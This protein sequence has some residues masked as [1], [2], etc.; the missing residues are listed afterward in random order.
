MPPVYISGHRNPDTDSIGAA[1]GYAELKSHLDPN[2][3]Y[4]PVRLGELNPQT[5]WVLEQAGLPAPEYLS[6]VHLR[7][8]DLMQTEFPTMNAN[9]SIREAGLALDHTDYDLVPVI[10]DEGIL[11][12][13]ITTRSLARRYVRE[14]RESSVLREATS[15]RA[16]VDV[17]DG[18]LLNGEDRTLSGRIWVHA[19]APEA[20]TGIQHS[21]I[22]V[23]GDRNA[24]QRRIIEKGVALLALSRGT[25]P[26]P[27]VLAFAKEKGVAMI[28]SPLDTYVTARMI[29]LAGPCREL[30]ENDQIIATPDELIAE[31]SE[32]IKDSHHGAAIIV[33]ERQRPIGL[34]TRSDLVSPLRRRVILVDH[35]EQ[36]QSVPGIEQA[37]IVEILD[38][39]H[40]GS[41]ETK[42]P[43]TAT[44]DPV[45]STATLVIERF[46]RSGVEPSRPT[47]MLLLAAVLADTVI[48]N[49]PTTTERDAAVVEYLERVLE[50]DAQRFG[51]RMFAETSD[52]SDVSAEELVEAGRQ[53]L[54]IRQWHSV[55]DRPGRGRRQGPARSRA[56][57]AGC[58]GARTHEAGCR[59]LRADGHRRPR[60]GDRPADRRRC[61]DRRPRVRGRA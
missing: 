3:E 9:D 32:Q 16:I 54:S 8:A 27:E 5:R 31:V 13:I 33:D 59:A 2:T 42:V 12:G 10:D 7:A 58:D 21:D 4:V 52:V 60:Q 47:A 35:A 50:I 36:A 57:A 6:H 61:R 41:I 44:F 22:V 46:R 18:E 29:T 24:A 15:L 53:G 56:G 17:L 34:V 20:E 38:H 39:H 14:S 45:G 23:V 25:K 30:M 43:V 28:S 19:S 51:R 55:P 1:V 49:S 11:I 48:L 40:I 37:E 26:T